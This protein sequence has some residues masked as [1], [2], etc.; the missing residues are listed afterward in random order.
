M[1]GLTVIYSP[2]M[3]T[4]AWFSQ[5]AIT[6]MLSCSIWSTLTWPAWH[7]LNITAVPSGDSLGA[8]VSRATSPPLSL[9]PSCHAHLTL[10]RNPLLAFCCLVTRQCIC[11][12]NVKFQCEELSWLMAPM[13]H[14][15]GAASIWPASHFWGDISGE[16]HSLSPKSPPPCGVQIL[17]QRV[18]A[19]LWPQLAPGSSLVREGHPDPAQYLPPQGPPQP[20]STTCSVV[21][22][23]AHPSLQQRGNERQF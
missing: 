12:N 1:C 13:E 20:L 7:S 21:E 5:W 14:H 9:P 19:L 2:I 10:V 4:A 8:D 3:G 11:P 22:G 15:P 18:W 23:R 6:G 16:K 17:S